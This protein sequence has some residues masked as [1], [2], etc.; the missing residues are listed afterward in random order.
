MAGRRANKAATVAVLMAM[1]GGMTTLVVYAEDLYRMFCA[2]TGYGGTTRAADAAP[3]PVLD[4]VVTVSFNA[5]IQKDLPWV[6]QPAQRRMDLRVGEPQLAFY[7]A[8]SKS[9]GPVTGTA[10]FNVTPAKAGPY[11]VKID[12]FCFTKQTLKAGET[13]KM[14]VQFYID[15]A[16][17]EDRNLDDVSQIT[18]S[19]TFFKAVEQEGEDARPQRTTENRTG[20]RGPA[21]N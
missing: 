4:R 5:D 11:F 17:A 10:T 13:V 7:T 21:V 15:P 20:P 1:I 3:G 18:L 9:D 8:T 12:C 2:A 14:P 16:I 19:Y 6:F